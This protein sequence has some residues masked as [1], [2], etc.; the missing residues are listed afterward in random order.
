MVAQDNQNKASKRARGI[1]DSTS[2]GQPDVARLDVMPVS[3]GRT[4]I[5]DLRVKGGSALN[6]QEIYTGAQQL[7]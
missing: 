6:Q 2:L 3:L 1:S 4:E 5:K 7:G